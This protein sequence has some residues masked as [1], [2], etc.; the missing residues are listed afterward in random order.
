VNSTAQA[1]NAIDIVTRAPLAARLSGK[2]RM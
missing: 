2:N 1:A